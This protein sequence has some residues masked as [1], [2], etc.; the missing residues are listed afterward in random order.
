MHSS[1]GGETAG[2]PG[3]NA[4]GLP[5]ARHAGAA[6]RPTKRPSGGACS[7]AQQQTSR[8]H[9]PCPYALLL[10]HRN[11]ATMLAHPPAPGARRTVDF[12]SR[13]LASALRCSH[14]SSDRKLWY[15]K[16]RGLQDICSTLPRH[17]SC[18]RQEQRRCSALT[19]ACEPCMSACTTLMNAHV[20]VRAIRRNECSCN[21]QHAR[22]PLCIGN[23]ST[24]A[25]AKCP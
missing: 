7:M 2:K 24:G 15:T 20:L 9:R 4:G 21:V 22:G 1:P 17:S 19:R 8:H 16:A 13:F 12:V 18:R 11:T 6:S 5:R 25:G 3:S 10:S 23:S 14:S